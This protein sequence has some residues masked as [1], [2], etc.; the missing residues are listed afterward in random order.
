M[1][2]EAPGAQIGHGT[3]DVRP[4]EAELVEGGP[5]R[6]DGGGPLGGAAHVPLED[7]RREHDGQPFRRPLSQTGQDGLQRRF[8]LVLGAQT[9]GQGAAV[10]SVQP[11]AHLAEGQAVQG[12]HRT[13]AGGSEQSLLGRTFQGE[14]HEGTQIGP[15]G[16]F[17]QRM[18]A[19]LPGD[20]VQRPVKITLGEAV[21]ASGLQV[22]HHI[23]PGRQLPLGDAFAPL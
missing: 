7:D 18:A 10:Q 1:P 20:G 13:G 16:H 11:G 17:F 3:L 5:L 19:R 23:I 12:Q 14:F 6:D 9:L 15:R 21:V 4:V 8:V 22:D 2:P